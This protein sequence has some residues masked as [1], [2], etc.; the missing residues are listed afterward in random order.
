[1]LQ[2]VETLV[3]TL[4]ASRAQSLSQSLKEN[5]VQKGTKNASEFRADAFRR[6]YMKV[7]LIVIKRK[8]L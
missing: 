5:A 1:M 3:S 8:T 6:Q 2:I 4:F 7:L